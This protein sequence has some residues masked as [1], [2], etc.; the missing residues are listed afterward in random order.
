MPRAP[1][2]SPPGPSLSD[3]NRAFF[4]S[5]ALS[6]SLVAAGCGG[7]SPAPKRV[8]HLRPARYLAGPDLQRQ[9][10]NAVAN[11][12]YQLAVMSQPS[13]DSTNLGQDLPTGA[14]RDVA[15]TQAGAR[16]PGFRAWPWHCTARWETA[17]GRPRTTRYAVRL[18]PTGCFAAGAH[19]RLPRHRDTTIKT[20]SEHPLNALASLQRGC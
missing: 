17:G 11:G 4:T 18:L 20:Y 12:L 9:L 13:D 16:P 7:G 19:P 5:T 2:A 15:C 3:M 14:V 10:S 1:A 8:A 6:L